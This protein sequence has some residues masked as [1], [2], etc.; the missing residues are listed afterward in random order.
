[1]KKRKRNDLILIGCLLLIGIF[2]L[3]GV[4]WYKS[5]TTKNGEAIVFVEGKEIGRYSLKQ[6]DEILIEGF[7]GT[8]YLI[9]RDGKAWIEEAQCPDKICIHAGKI[10]KNGET[11]VCLP[12]KVV[13]E[14]VNGTENEIDISTN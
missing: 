8:N 7:Q 2:S 6:D 12:N 14:I 10:S 3:L 9:I 1:M 4:E 11:I 13:V 5:E